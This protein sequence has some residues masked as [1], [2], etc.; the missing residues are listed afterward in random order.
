MTA[1]LPGAEAAQ[2]WVPG[3]RCPFE[4]GTSY[5]AP[6]T[7]DATALIGKLASRRMPA[8]LGLRVT[9]TM[10]RDARI[11]RMYGPLLAK[12][13]ALKVARKARSRLVGYHDPKHVQITDFDPFDPAI[14]R[15]PYPH[16]RELLAGER[17]QFNP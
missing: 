5:S 17:V 11:A 1:T 16:Y 3:G 6:A 15:D 7:Q 8:R 2:G 9:A 14:A 12:A 10:K 13:L 4:R